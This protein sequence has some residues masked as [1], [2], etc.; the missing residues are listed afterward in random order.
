M[1]ELLKSRARLYL[2][3][4]LDKNEIL[5]K[6]ENRLTDKDR[7]KFSEFIDSELSAGKKSFTQTVFFTFFV[8]AIVALWVCVIA[9]ISY[10]ENGV[11]YSKKCFGKGEFISVLGSP[12]H[13]KEIINALELIE[14]S[15]CEYFSFVME[16]SKTINSGRQGLFKAGVFEGEK[17][18]GVDAFSGSTYF[19]SSV[20]IHEACHSFQEKNNRPFSEKDCTTTQFNYLKKINAP[21]F[22]IETIERLAQQSGIKG[23]TLDGKDVFEE[24]KNNS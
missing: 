7:Q 15:S 3:A 19:V 12:D 11:Y 13:R 14:N 10:F 2:K 22:E 5:K 9:Y 1:D 23:Y 8:L 20:I 24:W 17:T 6:I 21:E 4:G 16:N 18:L